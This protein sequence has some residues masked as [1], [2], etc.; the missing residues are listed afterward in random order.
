MSI[1]LS[2]FAGAGA[3][4]FDDNGDPLSGGR[5][6]TY[7]AGTTTPLTTYTSSSNL[8]AH[9][10]PIV[11]NAAGRVPNGGEIWLTEG[12][13]YKFILKT[14]N[15]VLI[16]TYD[17]IPSATQPPAANDAN[18]IRFEPGYIVSAGNFVTGTT[19]QIVSVGTTD[20][21]LIG[22]LSNTSGV[23]FTATGPGT[24]TG[25]AALSRTTQDKLRDIVS[26]KD[27]GALGDGVTNDA[28]AIQNALNYTIA[29]GKALYFP[30]GTYIITGVGLT[31][32]RIEPTIPD[33]TSVVMFGAGPGKTI[34]KEKSGDTL[35]YG[36]FH[37]MLY[38]N[39]VGSAILNNLIV[40]DMTFDKNGLSNGPPPIPFDWE[41]AHIIGVTTGFGTGKVR[42]AL[43]SNVEML[44]KVG[45]GIVF[46]DGLV[47]NA[48]ITN[49]HSRNFSYLFGERGDFEFQAAVVNL[50]VLGCSGTY[51]QCEPDDPDPPPNVFPVAA[52]RDCN[53]N[54]LEFTAYYGT[55]ASVKAQTIVLDNCVAMGKLTVGNA[56]LLA[57]NCKFVVASENN[58]FWYRLAEGSV[59]ES[60]TIINR[61]DA[62]TNSISSFYPQ[63]LATLGG[64]YL[65]FVNCVFEP[66]TGANG[67]TSGRAIGTTNGDYTGAQP[68]L[69]RFTECS[70]SPLYEETINAYATGIYEFIRCKIAGRGTQA[71]QVGGF[72]TYIGKLTFDT[73]DFS[74]VTATYKV[75]YY[76]NNTLWELKWRGSHNYADYSASY[77]AVNPDLY[78]KFEGVFVAAAT[79]T[80]GGIKGMRVQILNP[81]ENAGSTYICTV[82]S[83]TAST[84]RMENQFGVK[85]ATTANRPTLTASDIGVV[86]LDT[87][88]DADGK[89]IWWTGTAWVDATGATV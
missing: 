7:A 86:Y 68:F 32:S 11:L 52:F 20:F 47:D 42:Y 33:N 80:A 36:R 78:T 30:E 44:D 26:V 8:I 27:F 13:G 17:N 56:K 35:A 9:S 25:T 50:E 28:P 75:F 51:A 55:A 74:A 16:A 54:I 4:F 62:A 88:L 64:F 82:N 66:G 89:P 87:T 24:G 43:F 63:A 73:C 34:I 72:S 3:Q 84:W 67:S 69:V 79:P 21:T 48:V 14:S 18:S 41:Q 39:V 71:A 38:F 37:M 31:N 2:L 58:F 22:A 1:T 29:N 61:Y 19:Y 70:F 77:F 53:I 57:R 6:Y 5:I 23:Y 49:C 59:V 12:V 46:M 10:N 60:S 40:R 85:K 45:G 76:N 83:A 81:V 15:D 65:D